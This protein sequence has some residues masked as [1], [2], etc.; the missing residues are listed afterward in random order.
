MHNLL[1]NRAKRLFFS[2]VQHDN[3][4]FLFFLV[5]NLKKQKESLKMENEEVVIEI[6]KMRKE[7]VM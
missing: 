2:K 4:Y 7:I 6:K 1:F 5:F 3:L